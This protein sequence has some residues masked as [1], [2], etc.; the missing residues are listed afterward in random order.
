MSDNYSNLKSD[1]TSK[2]IGEV[3]LEVKDL[4]THLFTKRGVIKAVDG[5]NFYLRKGET[6][7]IVGESGSGKSMTALSVLRMEP[8]PAGRIISGE[9]WLNGENLIDKT[10]EQMRKIRGRKISMILQDPQAALNPVFTIGNQVREAIRI[11]NRADNRERIVQ[12][13]IDVIRKVNIADPELRVDD[14][15]HQMSGGMKQR[16]AG[17]I[18]ISCEPRII[19][20]DE[21]TTSL[22]L[23]IQA[24]YLRLLRDIQEAMGVSIIFI[25]HDFGIVAKMCDRVAVMYAG[26]FVEH[27]S[28]RSVFNRPSHP[29]TQ[30]LMNSVPKIEKRASRLFSIPGTVLTS[31][32]LPA[33]CFFASRCMYVDDRCRAVYPPSFLGLSKEAEHIADC[34]RLEELTWEP[35]PYSE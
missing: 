16:V 32:N 12:K 27:G 10:E 5:V 3:I 22:D 14:Y 23:T 21:P 31:M 4:R 17:A 11:H 26:R 9:I 29:Y 34:W 15:P 13:A 8:K 24:Q 1:N 35:T 2:Q 28:V 30:A 7:G 19:I 6:F 25:T 18:S 20:A 33:G